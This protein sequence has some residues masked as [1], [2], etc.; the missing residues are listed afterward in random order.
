VNFCGLQLDIL[1]FNEYIY[2]VLAAFWSIVSFSFPC[3][4][5]EKALEISLVGHFDVEASN[6]SSGLLLF[7]AC[8]FLTLTLNSE[9]WLI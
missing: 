5:L 6:C 4:F 7:L 2:S 9:L 8:Y 3:Y 1:H